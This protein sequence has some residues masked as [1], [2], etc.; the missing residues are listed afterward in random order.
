MLM[1]IFELT[2]EELV[3]V[4][5]ESDLRSEKL[6]KLKNASIFIEDTPA[7]TIDMLKEKIICYSSTENVRVI[8]LNNLQLIK[9]YDEN[10]TQILQEIKQLAEENQITI[11]ALSRFKRT[12]ERDF[13]IFFPVAILALKRLCNMQI[14]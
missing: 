3:H 8:M 4:Q 13:P 10:P 7:L 1:N 9:N 12:F 2:S 5:E 11:I 6:E 14:L